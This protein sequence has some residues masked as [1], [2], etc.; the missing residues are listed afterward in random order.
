MRNG[1]K[2]NVGGQTMTVLPSDLKGMLMGSDGPT[3]QEPKP[4]GVGYWWLIFATL[5]E[6]EFLVAEPVCAWL[7]KPLF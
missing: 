4:L 5:L 2:G 3:A 1:I 7:H 6:L